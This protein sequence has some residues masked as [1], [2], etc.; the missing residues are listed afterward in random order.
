MKSA[1]SVPFLPSP[2]T[3]D[4]VFSRLARALVLLVLVYVYSIYG[5]LA[6]MTV[7][8]AMGSALAA[9]L[10]VFGQTSAAVGWTTAAI[11]TL[12]PI[13]LFAVVWGRGWADWKR[14]TI[15]ALVALPIFAYLR[16]DD[17]SV[18][19]PPQWD[20]VVPDT[21]ANR[22]SYEATLWFNADHGPLAARTWEGGRFY[23]KANISDETAWVETIRAQ[24][25]EIEAEWEA[26]TLGRE[27]FD[28]MDRCETLADLTEKRIDAP[29]MRFQPFRRYLQ[30]ATARAGLRVLDGDGDGAVAELLPLLRVSRKVRTGSR[31][32]VR[33]M[34][35]MVA[36]R[37][38][39]RTLRFVLKSSA[40]SASSRQAAIAA[41]R[42]G[43][44]GAAEIGRAVWIEYVMASGYVLERSPLELALQVHDN[45]LPLVLG[46]YL[47]AIG[48][49]VFNPR[50][51]ANEL[52][53]TLGQ[54]AEAASARDLAA[55]KRIDGEGEARRSRVGF[56][57]A[58]GGLL[59][60]AMVPAYAKVA[61]T[62]WDVEDE[63][64]ATLAALRG[65]VATE[66]ANPTN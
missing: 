48:P 28:T 26:F 15:G 45:K 20:V 19:T 7:V 36:E 41:L 64:A 18:T 52:A 8:P 10:E 60:R 6:G 23:V 1:A 17:P 59:V 55:V 66:N 35:A 34:V 65:D 47:R 5:W 63:R 58:L 27:W 61:G 4:G 37:E 25:A 56:K 42:L 3:R 24:R 54:I 40:V 33:F 31:T 16:R 49:F 43:S 30:L 51:T 13:G 39:M 2:V 38:A 21:A 29:I 46:V 22:A 62:F 57:N 50:R 12:V 44:E 9:T 14:L 32:L 53:A 11:F